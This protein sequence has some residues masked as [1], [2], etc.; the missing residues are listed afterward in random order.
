MHAFAGGGAGAPAVRRAGRVVIS[1]VWLATACGGAGSRAEPGSGLVVSSSTSPLSSTDCDGF[2]RLD[3][4]TPQGV[5]VGIAASGFTKIRGI[6]QLPD[7]DL[8]VAD[9]GSLSEATGAVLRLRRGATGAYERR[10]LVNG[11]DRPA[12]VAV[13][14]DRMVYVA[15]AGAVVRLDPDAEA[16]VVELVIGGLP[17]AAQL[18]QLNENHA[19]KTIAFAEVR[20]YSL[21]RGTY[22][23]VA[24]GLRN[25]FAIAVHPRSHLLLAADNGRDQIDERDPSLTPVEGEL[26]HEALDLLVGVGGWRTRRNAATRLAVLLRRRQEQSR[27]V[28]DPRAGDGAPLSP[29]DEPSP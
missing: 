9:T 16:P 13:G 29:V 17:N 23:V 26:P 10:L 2:N 18:P 24:S 22:E 19:Y 14:P 15:T 20:H 5:C 1:G 11:L 6:A 25:P 8:V 7:G 4:E 12:S 3:V 21:R 28:Y 27:I